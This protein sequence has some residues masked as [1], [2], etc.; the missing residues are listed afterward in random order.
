MD[1]QLISVI[2]ATYNRVDLIGETIESVLTQTYTNIELI[3]VDDGSTDNTEELVRN[4]KDKRIKYIKTDNWGGPARPRNIGIKN[5]KGKYIAFCDDDDIWLP[6]KLEYVVDHIEANPTVDMICHDEWLET[7]KARRKRVTCGPY[8]T[9]RDLLFN[10][11]CFFTSATVVRRQR[12]LEVGGFSED[13]RFNGTEDCDLWLRLAHA[14]CLIEYIHK[15]LGVYRVKGQ[16]I[17]NNIVVHNQNSMNVLD[18]HFQRW[19]PK[20]L[21]YRYLIGRSR[22]GILRSGGHSFMKQGDYHEAQRYL[23]MALKQDPFNWKT[24]VLT[25]LNIARISK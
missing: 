11:N 20:T 13:M 2:V 6:E 8:T 21:Y 19:Q 5:A 17:T 10:G 23:F 9:Y 3:I 16:G 7:D 1:K 24:W 25:L 4:Y 14:N 15:I 12:I 18:A 22:A